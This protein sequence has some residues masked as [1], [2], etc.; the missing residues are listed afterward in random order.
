MKLSLKSMILAGALFKLIAFVF[1]SFLN[2]LLRPYG[3]RLSYYAG[4]V[5]SRL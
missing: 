4:L 5:V 3:G 1:I 2:L